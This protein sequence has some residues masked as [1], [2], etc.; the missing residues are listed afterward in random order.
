[1]PEDVSS[2]PCADCE[3]SFQGLYDS[4]LIYC[5]DCRADGNKYFISKS[6]F[7]DELERRK[8]CPKT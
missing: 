4:Q 6:D 5:L 3:H 2:N 1:M 8:Q 7:R